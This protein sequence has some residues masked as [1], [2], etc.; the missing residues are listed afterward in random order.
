LTI[1]SLNAHQ[2]AS[3]FVKVWELTATVTLVSHRPFTSRKGLV[4]CP[5]QFRSAI[6]HVII[7]PS[8]LH[9]A[10]TIHTSSMLLQILEERPRLDRDWYRRLTRPVRILSEK[11][12][13]NCETTVTLGDS[14][15][16]YPPKGLAR[17]RQSVVYPILM[18]SPENIFMNSGQVQTPL[19]A[20]PPALAHIACLLTGHAHTC[21][22]YAI[23]PQ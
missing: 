18:F 15:A 6:A 4:N 7:K 23:L 5:Y 12:W 10:P 16:S 19:H 13:L 2:Q 1:P 14:P 3:R 11:V 8:T 22:T 17:A 9:N 21:L 20:S